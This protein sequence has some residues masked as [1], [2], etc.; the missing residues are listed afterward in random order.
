MTV[1]FAV[2]GALC[3]AAGVMV[4]AWRAHVQPVPH[5]LALECEL[6]EMLEQEP[7]LA[8]TLG[9]AFVVFS[10]GGSDASDAGDGAEGGGSDGRALDLVALVCDR[11]LAGRLAALELPMFEVSTLTSPARSLAGGAGSASERLWAVVGQLRELHEDRVRFRGVAD[12]EPGED[13]RPVRRIR[14]VRPARV[15]LF[16]LL[17]TANG[18]VAAAQTHPAAMVAVLL[19]GVAATIIAAVDADTLLIDLTTLTLVGGVAL[20]AAAV[21]AVAQFGPGSLWLL[22]WVTLLVGGLL[23]G[24]NWVFLRLRGVQGVGA[25]DLLAVPVAFGVPVLVSGEL[26]LASALLWVAAVSA[27]VSHVL[28]AVRSGAGREVPLAFGPHLMWAHLAV[29]PAAPWILRVAFGL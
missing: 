1:I 29:L 19:L 11:E 8:S 16:G 14:K 22:L 6:A 26:L 12:W 28:A 10:G 3:G 5:D 15:L 20:V 27:I 9:P 2:V 18:I 7:A 21:S 17:G 25:G 24:A 4:A 13:G 23:F